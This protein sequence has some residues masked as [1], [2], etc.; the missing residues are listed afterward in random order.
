[1]LLKIK[2]IG[3]LFLVFVKSENLY[4]QDRQNNLKIIKQVANPFKLPLELNSYQYRQLYKTEQFKRFVRGGEWLAEPSAQGDLNDIVRWG[5]NNLKWVERINKNRTE[6]K[7]I[8]LS[9]PNS[10]KGIPIDS[11]SVYSEKIIKADF[12]IWLDE[13]QNDNLKNIWSGKSALTDDPPLSD[14]EFQTLSRRVDRFYQSALRWKLLS[15]YIP[16]L[17][18]GQKEDVRGYY[19]LKN[20][21]SR[22]EKLNNYK[23]LNPELKAN[24]RNW[25]VQMCINGLDWSQPFKSCETSVDRSIEKSVNLNTLY[26]GFEPKSESVWNDFFGLYFVRDDMSFKQVNGVDIFSIPF[27]NPKNDKIFNFVRNNTEDEWRGP[28]WKLVVNL[29]NSGAQA[30]IR[31]Q[32]GVTAHVTGGSTIVMDANQSLDDYAEQWTIRHEFGHVLGLVDCYHEFY[33]EKLQAIVN[34]QLDLTDLMCSRAGN[35]KPRHF[36]ILKKTYSN[37]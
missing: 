21:E 7:K 28:L 22:E 18:N 30:N 34:Y 19:F 33:D 6:D 31:F 25:L 16:Q 17:T 26:E 29:V 36:E 14:V 4:S 3:L 10:R 35:I 9:D 5:E 13:L 32:P 37:N 8:L 2:L 23:Q 11:P 15:P 1:M 12:K 24:I 27:L 20:L